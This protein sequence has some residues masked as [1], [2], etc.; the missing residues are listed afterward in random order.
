MPASSW[1]TSSTMEDS[2]AA[3]LVD[4]YPCWCSTSSTCSRVSGA[5]A[6]R[7]LS[8]FDT[9]GADTP[10][11]RA[12]SAMV[13]DGRA[14][15]ACASLVGAMVRSLTSAGAVSQKS[16]GRDAWPF[17]RRLG[18]QGRD[19]VLS[20]PDEPDTRGQRGAVHRKFLSIY[21]AIS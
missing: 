14:C 13:V 1:K 7:P 5:T 16:F 17:P 8:T 4:R 20:A 19:F 18:P 21:V 3:F 12:I 2:L 6:V 9:V 15:G 11:R 10:A